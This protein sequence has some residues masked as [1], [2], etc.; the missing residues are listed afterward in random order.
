MNTIEIISYNVNGIRSAIS[1]GL[2]DWI[3]ETNYDVYLFQE[4]KAHEA[5]IPKELFDEIGY[6]HYWFSA[7]KKGYSG[8]GI[9]IRKEHSNVVKGMNIGRYDFEGRLIRLDIGDITIVNSYFPSGSSGEER[10]SV[11]MD[12]LNDFYNYIHEL[13]KEK[14]KIIIS[15]DYNI[16]HQAIDIHDP[17]GNKN[18]SGFLPEEREWMTKYFNSGFIDTFRHFH[19]DKKAEYS[20]WSFRANARNNNKGWRIDYHAATKELEQQLEDA[21]IFMDV[22]HSDH[23]PIYLKIK[24]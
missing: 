17:V 13:K 16:C 5:D 20:W 9:L 23:C 10:Q 19:P 6:T 8:V 4:T 12:Y 22:K 3:K 21:K 18:S 2:V 24:V 15:G 14:K 7:Q 11:K 1:K